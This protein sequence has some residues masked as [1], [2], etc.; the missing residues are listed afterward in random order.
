M[1]FGNGERFGVFGR[2]V[3]I[4]INEELDIFITECFSVCFWV[5]R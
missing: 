2:R 4:G 5:E 1:G 3:R